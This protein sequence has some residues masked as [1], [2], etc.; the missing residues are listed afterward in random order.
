MV[1]LLVLPVVT[2]VTAGID[3]LTGLD[4]LPPVTINSSYWLA[5]GYWLCLCVASQSQKG[6]PRFLNVAGFK[7]VR[8]Q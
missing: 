7:A 4:G 6:R 2:H 3:D 8:K 5:I 1:C